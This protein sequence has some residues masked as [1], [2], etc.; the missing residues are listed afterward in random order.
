MQN[1][2]KLSYLW[3]PCWI[4]SLIVRLE[5]FQHIIIGNNLKTSKKCNTHGSWN[6]TIVLTNKNN[7]KVVCFQMMQS[8]N[9]GLQQLT[10]HGGSMCT[11]NHERKEWKTTQ[12]HTIIYYLLTLK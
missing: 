6:G 1:Y 4:E 2:K 10:K 8:Q 12:N 5:E 3:I 7:T 9:Y 11:K